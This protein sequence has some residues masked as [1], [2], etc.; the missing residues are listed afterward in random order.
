MI[1]TGSS[2]IRDVIAFPKTQ[3][4]VCLLTE[5]PSLVDPNQLE[6]LAIRLA[7]K[8]PPKAKGS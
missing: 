7:V 3:K 8:A 1:L 6:D 4:G 2:S 5:A